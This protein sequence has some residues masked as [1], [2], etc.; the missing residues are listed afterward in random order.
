MFTI[1]LLTLSI[2]VL[3]DNKIT[4][5]KDDFFASWNCLFSQVEIA[6]FRKL[7]LPTGNQ[8]LWSRLKSQKCNAKNLFK[9][10]ICVQK[11]EKN[12]VI[13]TDT[14]SIFWCRDQSEIFYYGVLWIF[15]MLNIDC[16]HCF[17]PRSLKYGK[18]SWFFEHMGHLRYRG[19]NSK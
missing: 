16:G 4:I 18:N 17:W 10:R 8:F 14:W 13:F 3:L 6:F 12:G 15:E 11:I 19:V 2:G 9:I 5:R 7:K 1:S